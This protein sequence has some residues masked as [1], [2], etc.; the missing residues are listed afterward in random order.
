MSS[1]I[2][3]VYKY[4]KSCDTASFAD[5]EKELGL[6]FAQVDSSIAALKAADVVV[7]VG[8][9]VF[10]CRPP[11]ELSQKQK[12][13]RKYLN[14]YPHYREI[15]EFWFDRGWAM[16]TDCTE[17]FGLDAEYSK[18]MISIFQSHDFLSDTYRV[19][20]TNDD[21]EELYPNIPYSEVIFPEQLDKFDAPQEE[22]QIAKT[23]C[24]D[25][26]SFDEIAEKTHAHSAVIYDIFF[27][28]EKDEEITESDIDSAKSVRKTADCVNPDTN[29]ELCDEQ[30]T[31]F[32]TGE[33]AAHDQYESD[34]EELLDSDSCDSDDVCPNDCFDDFD[35]AFF[36]ND[37]FE[38]TTDTSKD[39][40][41]CEF[42]ECDNFDIDEKIVDEIAALQKSASAPQDENTKTNRQR[43]NAKQISS[44]DDFY[45]YILDRMSVPEAEMRFKI[46]HDLWDM[47]ELTEQVGVTLEKCMCLFRTKSKMIVGLSDCL[48]EAYQNDYGK[49]DQLMRR[50]LYELSMLKEDEYTAIREVLIAMD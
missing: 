25:K 6:T 5:L 47:D 11:C 26:H 24:A 20:Y 30:N 2:A 49:F 45:L 37:S 28:N 50:V 41:E 18:R 19:V 10:S 44:R 33:I 27:D 7:E 9:G 39:V 35:E 15:A 31:D 42:D 32:E 36:C 1:T 17:K 48:S 21:W 43:I 16:L 38:R 8:D 29:D 23:S 13:F 46:N 14:T 3:R 34:V 12:E 22:M 40:F 4:L